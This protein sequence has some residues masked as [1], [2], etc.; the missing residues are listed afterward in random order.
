MEWSSGCENIFAGGVVMY[1]QLLFVLQSFLGGPLSDTPPCED[2]YV[3]RIPHELTIEENGSFQIEMRE[4]NLSSNQTLHIDLPSAFTL[5]DSHGKDDIEGHLNNCSFVYEMNDT[6][7][8]IVVY[9]IDEIPVGD[10]HGDLSIT[11]CLE[12]TV[13]SNKLQ[14]GSDINTYL[15]AL[16]PKTITFSVSQTY[17]ENDTDVS[18]ANDRSVLAHYENDEVIIYTRDNGTMIANEDMSSMFEN[19]NNLETINGLNIPD[20]SSCTSFHKLFKGVSKLETISGI[21][22]ID[23]GNIE[24]MSYMFD[25]CTSITRISLNTLDTSNCRNM[26]YMFSHCLNMTSPGSVRNWDLSKCEN[27]SH[28]FYNCSKLKNVG[29]MASWNTAQV[30][31]MSSMFENCPLLT[32]TGN[33]SSWNVENVESF[34][35]MFKAAA[36]MVNIGDLSSWSISSKCKDLSKMF[37]YSEDIL[38]S[39]LDLRNW[40]VSSVED[41]SGMFCNCFSINSIDIRGWDTSEVNDMSMMFSSDHG[42]L[43]SSLQI[44]DGLGDIDVSSVTD[45]NHIFYGNKYLNCDL[46]GWKDSLGD[47]LDLSYA[48]WGCWNFDLSSLKDWNIS[49]LCNTDEAFGNAAGSQVASDIPDWYDH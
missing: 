17:S 8:R 3:I 29:S 49:S 22:Y 45:M 37:A 9:S 16:E 24:D 40:D 1:L 11:I 13:I 34:N 27:T 43:D 41:M 4:N 12:T 5:S 47:L 39:S 32:T 19:L 38:P 46:S 21:N 10:W 23:T 48:F 33:I 30:R 28:M 2:T 35:S 36:S 20:L 15:D 14:K 18:A 42:T 25:G 44:V 31:D 6:G 26:S 7:N